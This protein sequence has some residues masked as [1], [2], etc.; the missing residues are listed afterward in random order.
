M[1]IVAR[2]QICLFNITY[3]QTT[4]EQMALSVAVM[5]VLIPIP[6]FCLS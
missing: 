4:R 1:V 6:F 2:V 3:Y 5:C